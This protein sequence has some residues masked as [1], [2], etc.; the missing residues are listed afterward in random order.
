MGETRLLSG[1]IRATGKDHENFGSD[2]FLRETSREVTEFL[3]IGNSEQPIP[4][5][6]FKWGGECRIEVHLNAM[7]LDSGVVQVHGFTSFF[8]GSSEDTPDERDRE[9]LSFLVPRFKPPHDHPVVV[10][11][12]MASGPDFGDVVI[13]LR[14]TPVD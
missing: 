9:I 10:S 13:S 8:E 6:P 1:S 5:A 14:N 4:V 11:A 7:A 2:E 3:E 12:H